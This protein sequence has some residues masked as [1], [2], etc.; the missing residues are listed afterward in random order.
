MYIDIHSKAEERDPGGRGKSTYV[1][2]ALKEAALQ[3]RHDKPEHLGSPSWYVEIS[4]TS[5]YSDGRAEWD[6]V[7][8]KVTLHL[9]PTD[10]N[11]LLKELLKKDLIKLSGL[12]A[13]AV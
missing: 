6:P 5:N 12:R 11:V 13:N 10:I 2:V 3:V 1:N 4:D 7:T 8:R 9:T